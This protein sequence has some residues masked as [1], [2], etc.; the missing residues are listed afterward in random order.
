MIRFLQVNVAKNLPNVKAAVE[1]TNGQ[2][3][4]YDPATGTVNNGRGECAWLVK[5]AEVYNGEKAMRMPSDGDFEVIEA[6]A[7]CHLVPVYAGE[8]YATSQV[9]GFGKGREQA[10]LEP[11]ARIGA[12]GDHFGAKTDG[13]WILVGEYNDPTGIHMAEIVYD[14]IKTAIDG[15]EA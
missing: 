15:D 5:A 2:P 12:N 1:L 8:H 10:A 4:S 14:P 7:I 13:D 11:G 9:A 3:V 6:G